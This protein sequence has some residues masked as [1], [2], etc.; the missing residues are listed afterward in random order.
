[1]AQPGPFKWERKDKR[2]WLLQ[3][4]LLPVQ[5]W[6]RLMSLSRKRAAEVVVVVTFIT[7]S[8]SVSE[9]TGSSRLFSGRRVENRIFAIVL[10]LL[11]LSDSRVLSMRPHLRL[12]LSAVSLILFVLIKL[13]CSGQIISYCRIYSRRSRQ[14]RHTGAQV[15]TCSEA[16]S[17]CFDAEFIGVT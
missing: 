6:L 4:S 15:N 13:S 12:W 1:M 2:C 14:D 5:T 10:F 8:V 16:I 7:G 3:N 9:Q 17:I 11:L